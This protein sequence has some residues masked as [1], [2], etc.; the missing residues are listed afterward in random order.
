METGQKHIEETN[1]EAGHRVDGPSRM[2]RREALAIV[3][4]HAVYTVPA[5]LAVLSVTK[6]KDAHAETSF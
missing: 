3:G 4:K 6:A 1:P 5:V 2:S